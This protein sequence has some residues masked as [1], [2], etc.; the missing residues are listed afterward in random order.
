MNQRPQDRHAQ[1]RRQRY[2]TK[3]AAR[4]ANGS[5][6]VSLRYGSVHR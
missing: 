3:G 6:N 5:S 4:F 2:D 1:M